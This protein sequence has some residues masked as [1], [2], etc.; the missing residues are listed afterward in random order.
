[1]SDLENE[2]LGL[3]EDDPT[4]RPSK[5]RHNSSDKKK[6]SKAF[7]D[8]DDDG[9]ADMDLDS[10]D[11]EPGSSKARGP[12]RNPYPLEGK[13]VD[14]D[15]REAL[16]ALPEIERENILAG[17]LE[18]MQKFKDSQA[19]D[20]MF[21][22]LQGDEDDDEPSRKRRKHTSVTKEASRAMNDLKNKRKAKDERAQRRAARREHRRPR[23]AS[24]VSDNSTE[25][26]EISHSYRRSPERYSPERKVASPKKES[27]D[28]DGVPANRQELN[29]ARLSR[30]ELVDIMYRDGFEG[31]V[32]G[33]DTSERFGS[34]SIEYKGRNVRDGRGLLCQYGKATR[35]FRIADVS[36]GDFE[37]KEFTRFTMTNQAD[38]VKAPKRSELKKKH[39]EIKALR[40]RPMSDVEINR[41]ITSR[42]ARDSNFNR[43]AHLKIQQLINT[44]DLAQRRNDQATVDRLNSEIV[45]LGGDPVTGQLVGGGEAEDDYDLRI[46][47]INENNKKKTKESMIKAHTAALARKKAE[48]AIIKAKGVVSE[49]VV[50]P[51]VPPA[52]GLKK[53]ET[54]QQYVA[55]TIDLDLGDF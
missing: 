42:Q 14:E 53:G 41:Q 11:D 25:D 6:K 54:P 52:S 3:A 47:R 32:T 15:D 18:E 55:R 48:E 38:G 36:N 28:L 33:V 10:D 31:V 37:E 20:A 17:R 4:R 5:K 34:Y 7:M 1:M 50:E 44:R 26:G 21:Q 19:L 43:S 45:K 16:E 35:L 24:P 46:Q 49:P 2:L 29:S 22:T 30:Y 12:V 8:S 40:D 9:E 51:V 23:S 13:Y 27:T 39:E